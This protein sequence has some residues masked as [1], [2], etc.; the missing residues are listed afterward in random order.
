MEPDRQTKTQMIY[1][2]VIAL[3][4]LAIHLNALC[5]FDATF[6]ID[7]LAYVSLGDALFD[8]AKLKS[9][10]DR[11][12][13]WSCRGIASEARAQDSTTSNRQRKHS[14]I[15]VNQHIM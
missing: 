9:F 11:I 14:V 8:P 3:V 12:G 6:W 13:H 10:Y 7:S 1:S 15:K 5:A 4:L 2:F